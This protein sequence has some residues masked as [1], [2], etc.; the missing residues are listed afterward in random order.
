MKRFTN[1]NGIT[2]IALIITII[3]MLILVAVTINY[4]L[5]G[6]LITKAKDASSQRQIAADREELQLAIVAAM[7]YGTGEI[8]RSDLIS[9]LSSGWNTSQSAP[10]TCTSPK[11]NIFTV[12]ADGTIKEER[13]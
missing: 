5:N 8:V 10:Y 3:V 13:K 7:D 2:L 6:G 1:E 4:S 12:S 9:S 11:G